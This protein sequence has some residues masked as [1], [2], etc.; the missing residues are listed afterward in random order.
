MIDRAQITIKAGDGGHGIASFLREKYNPKGGP[1]GGDGGQ[2]GNVYIEATDSLSTLLDF[3]YQRF[4]EAENG[5]SGG[6]KNM[7]GRNGQDLILKVPTGS[8][9]YV[10]RIELEE[11]IPFDE[12]NA[13]IKPKQYRQKVIN[14][15]RI[16]KEKYY[17]ERPRS[18]QHSVD[19]INMREKNEFQEQDTTALPKSLESYLPTYDL[20]EDGKK[21]LIAKGGMGGRGNNHFKSSSHQVPMESERGQKG[22][23]VEIIIVLKTIANIGIIGLPNAGKST[24]LASLTSA[25]PKIGNYPFTTIDPNLGVLKEHTKSI[26]L[27]DLPGLIQG[28]HQ[29]RGLGIRFLQ[30]IERTSL[31]LHVVAIPTEDLENF[32]DNL[33]QKIYQN[34]LDI[35]SEL[36]LYRKGLER[37]KE[38][39]VIN[40]IDLLSPEKRQEVVTEI[41]KLFSEH[42]L[43]PIYISAID[44]QG[45][46]GLR[47]IILNLF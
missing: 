28:A 19:K 18:G 36:I 13:L 34:Y 26:I 15:H 12:K 45:L 1:D 24:L 44:R 14:Y 2:G 8:V 46:A 43:Q 3:Q 27:A 23:L 39:V 32:S 25:T 20:S 5:K 6:S 29:G 31:L 41:N 35:R 38:I 11:E 9:I 10:K 16:A 47:K 42:A 7:H 40:K 4:F 33:A 37:K 22:E 17:Q 21:V 30:H